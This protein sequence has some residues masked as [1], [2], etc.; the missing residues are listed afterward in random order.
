M[1]HLGVLLQV[2]FSIMSG[3]VKALEGPCGMLGLDSKWVTKT[4][5]LGAIN[6]LQNVSKFQQPR[7]GLLTLFCWDIQK[8]SYRIHL[9]E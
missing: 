4:E 8:Q 3:E 7:S 6:V 9:N 1:L 5:I 2:L